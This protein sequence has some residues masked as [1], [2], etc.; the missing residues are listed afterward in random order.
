MG[1]DSDAAYVEPRGQPG[2]P[3]INFFDT[4]P[5]FVRYLVQRQQLTNGTFSLQ[6]NQVVESIL[7]KKKD[8]TMFICILNKSSS[9][10]KHK[11]ISYMIIYL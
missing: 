5:A 1:D 8:L 10:F 7:K 3:F 4:S 2:T 11:L 9:K 6:M